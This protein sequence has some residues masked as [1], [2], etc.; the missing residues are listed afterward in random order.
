MASEPKKTKRLKDEGLQIGETKEIHRSL[1]KNASYNPRVLGEAQKRKLK[2]GLKKHGLIGT[3]IWNERTGNIVGGHQR[4]KSLDELAGTPDYTLEAT[5]IDV[6]ENIE[7]EMNIL[8]NN[9]EA[10]GDWDMEALAGMLRDKDL[11]LA[12]A[13]LDHADV[14]R[15]FGDGLAV[16]RDDP[17]DELAA[18]VREAR[19]RYNQIQDSNEERENTEFY[20]VV[21]FRNGL[22]LSEFLKA[23]GLPDNRYQSGEEIMRLCG[24][25]E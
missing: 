16:E 14:F 18:K 15:M 1:L 9:Q 4:L 21:V 5:V 2:G 24:M 25:S 11:D 10:Q 6:P 23:G 17:L 22:Q 7:K 3:V 8:L 12:G 20:M 13:G 19:D